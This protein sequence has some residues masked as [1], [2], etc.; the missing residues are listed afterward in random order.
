MQ[1]LFSLALW[2]G[3]LNPNCLPTRDVEMILVGKEHASCLQKGSDR[4]NS[5]KSYQRGLTSSDWKRNMLSQ[6][7]PCPIRQRRRS[8]CLLGRARKE[9]WGHKILK[10]SVASSSASLHLLWTYT[11]DFDIKQSLCRLL[12]ESIC[13]SSKSF[14]GA[15]ISRIV[16]LEM[17]LESRKVAALDNSTKPLAPLD[18][19]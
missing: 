18:R 19:I 6:M 14:P 17:E 12:Q 8:R 11:F 2:K 7:H 1:E 10:E 5:L 3:W 9:F 15:I 13:I 4:P 16:P